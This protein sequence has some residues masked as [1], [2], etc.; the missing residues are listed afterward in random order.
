MHMH[1]QNLNEDPRG[2]PRGFPWHGRAWWRIT[3]R[4]CMRIEW[5]LGK[6]RCA[7]AASFGGGDGN[8]EL[9]L[10]A[11]IPPISLF[12]S[13]EGLLPSMAVERDTGVSIHDWTLWWDCWQN[14]NEWNSSDPKWRHGNWCPADTFLGRVKFSEETLRTQRVQ[15]PMPEGCYPA[16]IT[17]CEST[18]KRPRWFA[19]RLVRAKIDMEK[20]IPHPGKGENSWDCGDDATHG[21]SCCEDTV[22]GAVAAMVRTVLGSRRRHGGDAMQEWP[23]PSI[24]EV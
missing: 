2:R 8:D 3:D 5:L 15:I 4:V 20:P 22:E 6:P 23:A 21:L 13:V 24:S 14:A 19:K 10:H 17:I 18:W 16:T 12:W 7:L 9:Q 1:W 11:A